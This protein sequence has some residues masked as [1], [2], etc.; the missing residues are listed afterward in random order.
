MTKQNEHWLTWKS[1]DLRNKYFKEI[2]NTA[3]LLPPLN[4][5]VLNLARALGSSLNGTDLSF[6][7]IQ[8]EV[9]PI[10]F[11][12]LSTIPHLSQVTFM[13]LDGLSYSFYNDNDQTL[14]VFSNSSRSSLWFTQPV[15][16]DTGQLYGEAV[17]T[18]SLLT[19]NT[20]MVQKALNIGSASAYSSLG[21]GWNKAQDLHFFNTAPMDGRGVIS[22]SFPAKMV[23]ERFESIDFYGGDFHLA[24]SNS[25]VLV[26]TK[27]P[28]TDIV[29][30]NGSVLVYADELNSF[31]ISE[32]KAA[33]ILGKIRGTERTFYCSNIE[34]AGVPLVYVLSF[35]TKGLETE[36]HSKSKLALS[37]LVVVLVIVVISLCIF[38]VLIFRSARREMF[39]CTALVKQMD[40]TQQA[41]RKSM[42]KSLAFASASHD[43]RASLCA[44]SGLVEFCL[45]EATPH[46]ELSSNLKQ[47]NTCVMDLHG[48]LSCVLDRSK[49][50]AGKMQLQEEDFNLA[51]LLEH[52]ADMYYVVGIKKGVDVVFD[53]CDGSIFKHSQVKGDR[54]KIKQI[55]CNL[56][57]NAVKFT[58]DGHV[59]I[60]A[61]V[62]KKSKENEIIASN[63]T[64]FLSRL[65][66]LFFKNHGSFTELDSLQTVQQNPNC[67]EFEIEVDDTG[68][69]IPKDKQDSVFENFVQVKDADPEQEGCGLG[70]GIVQSL[71]RLMGGEIKIVDKE[72]GERG[73]RF[74]F[75][76]F[77]ATSQPFPADI[78][79]PGDHI[80]INIDS[81]PADSH[82]NFPLI[83]C[84]QSDRSHVVLV[85]AGDERRRISRR[86]IESYHIKVSTCKRGKDL[87]YILNKLKYKLDSSQ[88]S[89]EKNQS[90][91]IDNTTASGSNSGANCSSSGTKLDGL[92]HSAV[93]N[94]R[95]CSSRGSSNL[96]LIILDAASESFLELCSIVENFKKCMVDS[97]CKVVLL[98][99]P[100]TRTK[101]RKEAKSVLQF[102]YFVSKPF[103]GSYL[104]QVLGLLPEFG[105]WN[106]C[107]S[108]IITSETIQ[109][110]ESSVPPN[111]TTDSAASSG[112]QQAVIHEYE[113]DH[114]HLRRGN[115][116]LNGKNVLIVEDQ[117]IL[118]KL[119]T[120]FLSKLG[121]IVETCCDGKEAF[122]R[123]C[124]VLGDQMRDGHPQTLP[125]D[126]IFMDCE[127][128]VMDG[129]EATKLIRKEERNYGIRIPIIALTCHEMPEETIKI[130]HAGMNSQIRKP[131]H[132][133]KVMA[134]IRSIEMNEQKFIIH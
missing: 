31:N 28:G 115:K 101:A 87:S 79:E 24:T 60:R 43:V 22:I 128:P 55:L 15:N 39:L 51:D 54:G 134:A 70:L 42:N 25:Q 44:I 84:P 121:A 77:L 113:H 81:P 91:V 13:G 106:Q 8:T 27:L 109:D 46:S 17:G 21:L 20:S 90:R 85:I 14:A 92:D 38:I 10:L 4:S 129:F 48:I 102:D 100:V 118:R 105:S 45:D 110:V 56:I 93:L 61:V 64:G 9:A 78:E 76:I 97:L 88:S 18:R 83:R 132:M 119:A 50:E 12:A 40:A 126:Y 68:K 59:S 133:A 73:T 131:L 41:E 34:I 116:P 67:M 122:D 117:Q 11:V 30:Y 6:Q 33:P 114:D 89:P 62:K 69:G 103:H 80:S 99:N 75:N 94:Y 108:P 98:E 16:R 72:P 95:K 111:A 71:V 107:N 82:Q 26:Q 57:S 86:F 36:V 52:V 3:K 63:R 120:V 19:V 47:M 32:G 7:A 5:S 112:A 125:Y 37:F 130:H 49:I 96:V 65:S 124:K 23:T 127:M 123:V 66:R 2:E 35:P 104:K 74:R 53:H 29:V 58:S 1:N